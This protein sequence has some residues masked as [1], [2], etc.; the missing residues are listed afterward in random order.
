MLSHVS[1]SYSRV[2][3]PWILEFARPVTTSIGRMFAKIAIPAANMPW[4]LECGLC[5]AAGPSQLSN[6]RASGL[7]A[8]IGLVFQIAGQTKPDA[9]GR[10]F[11]LRL[12]QGAQHHA[13]L[14]HM[15]NQL[16]AGT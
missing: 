15:L 14:R 6:R 8:A 9:R 7:G 16:C 3:C 11:G 1:M 4:E 5:S 13:Q 10:G 12:W 2:F